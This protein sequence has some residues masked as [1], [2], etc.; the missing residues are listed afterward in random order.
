MEFNPSGSWTVTYNQMWNLSMTN[1]ISNNQIAGHRSFGNGN[2]NNFTATKK[3]LDYCWSFNKGAKCKFGKKCKF[4]ERCSY[5]DDP[6]HFVVNCNKLD[7]R[8]KEFMKSN[9]NGGS[10][11]GGHKTKSH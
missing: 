1:P 3:K 8:D 2:A 4:F 9:G 6:S 10:N 11:I 5:C 7:K